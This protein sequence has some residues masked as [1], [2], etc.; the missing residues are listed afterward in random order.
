MHLLLLTTVLGV[1]V[2]QTPKPHV[3]HASATSA[4]TV[5]RFPLECQRIAQNALAGS[6]YPMG[7]TA[8][9]FGIWCP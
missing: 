5:P 9:V 6:T 7:S 2:A 4:S 3:V 1:V 8:R